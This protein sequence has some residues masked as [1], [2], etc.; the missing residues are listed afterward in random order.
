MDLNINKRNNVRCSGQGDKVL[1]FAHGFGCDQYVWDDIAP[2][3][4]TKYRVVLFDYV[5]SGR[6]DKKAYSK[7]R[8]STLHGYK[9]DLIELCDALNLKNVVFIG[10]SVSSMIGALAA[11]DRPE[12]IKDLIMIGPSA[13]Y[14]NEPGYQGGFER[15][16]IEGMLK[17][18]ETDYKEWAN[19]LAPVV[20]Q[21]GDRPELAQEFEQILCS[22][23]PDIMRQFA[24]ATFLS[25]VR[26]DL[27]K[28][29]VP[30]LILQMK[31]DAIA[32]ET[33]GEFVHSQ[34]PESEYVV[35]NATGHNPHVSHAEETI[36]KILAYLRK[37][38]GN[39]NTSA[40]EKLSI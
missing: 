38:M 16:D 3:F 9:Q 18:M 37:P 15:A 23:D 31:N 27:Q 12:L 21:N 7:E 1:V 14:L 28:V 2:A 13:H 30:T 32:P 39:S 35:M 17:M 19:Y 34:I 6:S 29:S 8:Y 24:E 25:D 10:H 5:G 4:E 20:L 40:I 33:A 36:E 11:I 26:S 22:N